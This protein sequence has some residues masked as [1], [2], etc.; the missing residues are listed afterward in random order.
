VRTSE[1]CCMKSVDGV[2]SGWSS[3]RGRRQTGRCKVR[4]KRAVRRGVVAAGVAGGLV[5]VA[6]VGVA[7]GGAVAVGG[8]VV[9][10]GVAVCEGGV[11]DAGVVLSCLV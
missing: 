11:A 7:G 6:G 4:Q 1:A 10:L 2:G 5:D 3:R 9:A 8:G